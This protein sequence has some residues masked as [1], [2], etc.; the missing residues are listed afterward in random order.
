MRT[1]VDFVQNVGAGIEWTGF[2]VGMQESAFT[3][4]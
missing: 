2:V 3:L 4:P 1:Y